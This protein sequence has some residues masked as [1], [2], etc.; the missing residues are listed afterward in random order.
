MVQGG[1]TRGVSLCLCAAAL[2]LC[3]AA[4]LSAARSASASAYLG[5]TISGE[6][7]GQTGNAPRN[8]AAWETFERH[9]GQRVAILNQGQLWATFDKGEVEATAARGTIP[10]VTMG[11]AEGVTLEGIANGG[12][13]AAIKKW[14]QEAK[15]F[16][17]PFLFAP[18][19][20][21]NGGWYAWGKQPRFVEAWRRFHNI[22]VEQGASNVTWTWLVNSIWS[23]PESNPT[24]YYPGDAYVDWT[25]MDSYNW[26]RMPAQ[27]DRWKTPDQVITP[28]LKILRT[29]APTKP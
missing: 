11:L 14:A 28:T 24:R 16:G 20:E 29:V 13:D 22:V 21:M 4:N 25:G 3:A 10:L 23:D 12:Q 19:W 7:Y 5:A 1:L 9:A 27:S 17:K 26:G 8:L 15:A 2:L 6:T 18:W